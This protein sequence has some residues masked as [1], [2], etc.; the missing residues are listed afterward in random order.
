MI[1]LVAL[2]ASLLLTAQLS[3]REEKNIGVNSAY[4]S[5]PRMM[6][7]CMLPLFLLLAFRWNVGVDSVYGSS[8]SIAY[9]NA[10]VGINSVGKVVFEPGY[11]LLSRVFASAKVPFFW[12]LFAQAIIFF[13]F[14]ILGIKKGSIAPIW[15][16]LVFFCFT[17][18]FDEFS[19]LRQAISE[20]LCLFALSFLLQDG[21]S[22]K[23][24]IRYMAVVA[25]ACT[26]HTISILFIPLYFFLRIKLTRRQCL[27]ICLIGVAA[28]PVMK[29]I[30]RVISTLF[31][32]DKYSTVGVGVT[33][34]FVVAV[35]TLL[36]L[37]RYDNIMRL[38]ENGNIIMNYS[39]F[40]FIVM[41][42]SSALVLPFRVF[43]LLKIG[44]IFV[45]PYIVVSGRLNVVS[46]MQRGVLVMTKTQLIICFVLLSVLAF[47]ITNFLF[48]QHNVYSEYH[49]VFE[50]W[51]TYTSLF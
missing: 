24:T 42:N 26:F 14:I 40:A 16:V 23:S 36:C 34:V 7:L 9:H 12:F 51:N 6:W 1:Y 5:T 41:A 8:Y 31:Y 17:V 4:I 47:W 25:A 38:N 46:A 20:S 3:S 2:F 11:Y 48:I 29:V 37:L 27:W 13:F 32:G 30:I 21:F 44:Y 22:R 50:N 15:S 39:V 33:Y 35:I 10:A 43:D 45:I 18:F 19:S 49:S 28:N